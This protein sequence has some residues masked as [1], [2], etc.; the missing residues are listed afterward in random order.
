ME[1]FNYTPNSAFY[2]ARDGNTVVG[3]ELDGGLGRYRQDQ[4]N[5][6]HKVQCQWVLESKEDFRLWRYFYRGVALSGASRFL[7]DLVIDDGEIEEF[8]CNFVPGTYSLDS[9]NGPVHTVSSEIEV[10]P[11]ALDAEYYAAIWMLDSQYG[12]ELTAQDTLNQ[13]EI[14]V[15]IDFPNS[16]GNINP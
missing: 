12:D 8:T 3:T 2:T 14:L 15:N 9:I 7:M 4:L 16:L 1:K 6:S 10:K 13:L 5:A 11:N